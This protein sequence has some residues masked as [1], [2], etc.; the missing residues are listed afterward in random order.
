MP[1]SKVLLNPFL[2]LYSHSL[3]TTRNATSSYGGPAENLRGVGG[4][5]WFRG[6]GLSHAVKQDSLA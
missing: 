4:G 5:A 2:W 6:A 3:F 1:R